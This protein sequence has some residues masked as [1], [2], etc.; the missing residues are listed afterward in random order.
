MDINLLIICVSAV[1]FF[2]RAAGAV[3]AGRVR[4]YSPVFNATA[5]VVYAIV[6]ALIIKLI[7]Y[8]Q[9]IVE[10][11]ALLQRLLAVGVALG[12]FFMSR[13]VVVA[14]WTGPLTLWLLIQIW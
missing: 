8:P 1:T 10:D 9:G 11:T 12:V 2:W 6:G 3:V 14:A 5:C 13:N 7:I 4:A